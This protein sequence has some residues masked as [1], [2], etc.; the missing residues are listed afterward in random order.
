MTRAL[1]WWRDL[2]LRSKS[3]LA[4]S[5]P[6]LFLIAS[7]YWVFQASQI[8]SQAED[9]LQRGLRVLGQIHAVHAQLAEAAS[10]VRGFLLTERREFLQPFD[11]ADSE[12]KTRLADLS[13]G[14]LDPVQRELLDDITQLMSVKM[15]TLRAIVNGAGPQTASELQIDMVENK[16][17]LDRLRERISEMEIQEAIIIERRSER[18]A[19]ARQRN[20]VATVTASTLGVLLA[21][22]IALLFSG[23]LIDRIRRIGTDALRLEAGEITTPTATHADELGQLAATIGRVGNLLAVRAREAQNARAEAE[24]ANQ[25]KTDFLSR[26]S[27][28]L[29]TPLNAILG[30]AQLLDRDLKDQPAHASVT[31]ILSGGRHLATLVDEVLDIS[32]IESG[33]MVIHPVPVTTTTIVNEVMS[34]YRAEANQLGIALSANVEAASVQADPTRLRQVLIN[35]VDNALKYNR[36]GGRVSVSGRVEP[37]QSRY[38]I[39]VDDTGRGIDSVDLPR[40]FTPFERL[41]E[42]RIKGTGLGLTV[43]KKLVEAMGGDM[44]AQSQAGKGSCFWLHLPLAS[45]AAA[46]ES[47]A[48]EPESRP[49]IS[50]A[51]EAGRH[52]LLMVRPHVDTEALMRAVLRRFPGWQLVTANHLSAADDLPPDVRIVVFDRAEQASMDAALRTIPGVTVARLSADNELT[53]STQNPTARRLRYPLDV[54]EIS[55]LIENHS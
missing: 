5:T 40:L 41:G 10:G 55:T 13:S 28:E 9:D 49:A 15:M 44:G 30:F 1:S 46:A 47:P 14:V 19:S 52:V 16:A 45:A 3:A 32:R 33:S 8:A 42:G 24:T 53:A 25:L 17:L 43:S 39:D 48:L 26:A 20:L 7:V 21:A 38:R 31:P 22:T 35:L 12:I 4:I 23:Y 37:G 2:S 50:P 51:D 29:R 11:R 6:L 54:A 18:V 27:H 34:L 36:P